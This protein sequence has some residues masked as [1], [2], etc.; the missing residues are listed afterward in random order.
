MHGITWYVISTSKPPSVK[1]FEEWSSE[2]NMIGF[3][4]VMGDAIS[5]KDCGNMHVVP[6]RFNGMTF[7]VLVN[8]KVINP[9]TRIRLIKDAETKKGLENVIS[10]VTGGPD[11][12]KPKTR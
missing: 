4:W 6:K 8:N 7:N 10:A 12:K 1:S 11:A 5:E 3:W 2:S 9:N